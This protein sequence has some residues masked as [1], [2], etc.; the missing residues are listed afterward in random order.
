[1]KKKS[2]SRSA[3]FNPRAVIGL[4]VC[5]AGVLIAFFAF[6]VQPTAPLANQAENTMTRQDLAGLYGP[7]VL[8]GFTPPACVPG[9][10]I[11]NDV[12]ASSPFCPWI[13]ELSRRGIT[14]G[15][16]P[17]LFCP[18][19]PVRRQEMAVFI[20]KAQFPPTVPA[21]VTITGHFA[22]SGANATRAE[23]A[24]SFS[25]PFAAAPTPHIILPGGAPTANCPGSFSNPQA[26]PGQLCLYESQRINVGGECVYTGLS[27]CNVATEH[28]GILYVPPAAAGTFFVEGTWAA[29]GQ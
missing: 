8:A 7:L 1:M 19:N 24:I 22:A 16:A 23:G 29:T 14:G 10:E 27:L 4:F 17:G 2:T 26:A 20:V 13:E 6:G 18:G 5:L 28:G 9:S 11:F 21:G 3:F 25:V 12:P 15:C